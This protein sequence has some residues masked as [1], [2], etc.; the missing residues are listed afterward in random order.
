MR[1]EVLGPLRVV[2]RGEAVVMTARKIETVLAT[3]LIKS[4]QIV[5]VDQLVTEIWSQEPPRRAVNS[6]YVYISQL[7]KFLGRLSGEPRILTHAPGYSLDIRNEEFD[8]LLFQRL[9]GQGREQA[10]A[11]RHEAADRL[12]TEA[13]ALWRGPTLAGLHDGPIAT[14]F[15]AWTEAMRMECTENMIDSRLALG[16]HRELVGLLFTLIAEYPLR[17]GFYRQLMIALERCERRADALQV[18]QSAR[19]TLRGELGLAPG[20]AL[21]AVQLSILRAGD[22]LPA[23]A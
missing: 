3:L 18:Y 1:F 2:D 20:P 23:A 17:E 7:R 15:A 19:R 22:R 21:Q 14:S 12:F 10:R 13:L 4:G 8:L 5:S 16:R 6:V 9:L 11:G